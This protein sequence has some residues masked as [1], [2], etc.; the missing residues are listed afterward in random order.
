MSINVNRYG[1]KF[2]E[3]EISTIIGGYKIRKTFKLKDMV[4][5]GALSF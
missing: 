5:K 1:R 2:V 4:F 3:V